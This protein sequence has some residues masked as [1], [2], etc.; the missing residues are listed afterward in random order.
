MIPV[1]PVRGTRV[2]DREHGARA[3][4]RDPRDLALVE[5]REQRDLVAV[6]RV[7]PCG[8]SGAEQRPSAG[9]DGDRERRL[10]RRSPQFLDDAV[11]ADPDDLAPGRAGVVPVEPPFTPW[12]LW[13]ALSATG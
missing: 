13:Q 7:Q 5:G 10:G 11:R 12:R 2:A 6:D 8:L 9:V 3:E 4:R 1:E